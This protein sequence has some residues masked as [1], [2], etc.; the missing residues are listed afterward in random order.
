M[1][2]TCVRATE[3]TMYF[4]WTV[5]PHTLYRLDLAPLVYYLFWVLQDAKTPLRQQ[6]TP[7][8]AMRQ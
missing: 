3:A 4:G 1:L 2:P 7:Q 6:Q 8:N 5:L